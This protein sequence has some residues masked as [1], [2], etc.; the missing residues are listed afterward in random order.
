MGLHALK[1]ELNYYSTPK[2]KMIPLFKGKMHVQPSQ[3]HFIVISST[4]CAG[5]REGH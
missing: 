2:P 3:M 1:C 4:V 5:G